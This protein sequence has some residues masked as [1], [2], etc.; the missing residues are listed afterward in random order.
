VICTKFGVGEAVP[1]P[2]NHAKFHRCGFKNVGLEP[3]K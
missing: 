3:P 1:G 2:H